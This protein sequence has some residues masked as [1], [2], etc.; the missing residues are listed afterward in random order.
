MKT[1][2]KLTA[3]LLCIAMLLGMGATNAFAANIGDEIKWTVRY[4]YD[5]GDYTEYV[6]HYTLEG[7]LTEGENTITGN[8]DGWDY[9]A[10]EFNAAQAGY[11]WVEDVWC[12]VAE[13]YQNGEAKNYADYKE[14]YYEIG[15]EEYTYGFVYYLPAG[16]SL[17]RVETYSG[18]ELDMNI[19]F[20]GD[21][22]EIKFDEKA[23]ECLIL[24]YDAYYIE[25]EDT[26]EL[27]GVEFTATFSNGKTLESGDWYEIFKTNGNIG[28]GDNTLIYDFLG[29]ETE[30]TAGI[31]E[32]TD[33]VE[34]IELQ[35][36]DEHLDAKYYYDGSIE[37][38]DLG[39][40]PEYVTINFTDG[41]GAIVE[42]YY[43]PSYTNNTFGLPNGK[44]IY[45]YAYLDY[46]DEGEIC[47]VAG[48]ADH[49]YIEE[50]CYIE[51]A[52][53]SENFDRLTTKIGYYIERGAED[54]GWA[55]RELFYDITHGYW[56]WIS[57][58]LQNLFNSYYL[59][60]I[61]NEISLFFSNAF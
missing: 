60:R 14:M 41:T 19:E 29:Y 33:F 21:V 56:N 3:L 20:L 30:V 25:E 43:G 8:G 7:T 58:D 23:L 4:D 54:L 57:Y 49:N 59:K 61:F 50:P 32:I 11:Y 26:V 44:E 47:F 34:S 38:F 42:F 9:A 27:E 46:N 2:K 53:F 12:N 17:F 6:Y 39:D 15:E 1:A 28:S 22:S 18:E 35:K 10:Y 13:Q 37:Y 45:V 5:D 40:K 31:Y 51:S 52:S 55:I 48:I 16:T 24:D 36:Y